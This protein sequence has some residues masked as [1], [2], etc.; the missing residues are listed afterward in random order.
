LDAG[1]LG[2]VSRTAGGHRRISKAAVL[3]Y[4]ADS[5]ARQTKGLDAMAQASERL[6]LYA[7]GTREALVG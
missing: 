2:G 6:G 1:A 5:K 4:K 3:A 7:D